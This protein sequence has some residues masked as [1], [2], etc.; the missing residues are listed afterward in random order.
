MIALAA[1]VFLGCGK[2]S[3]KPAA[4]SGPALT[5]C[6]R[7]AEHFVDL[8]LA[9]TPP[10][11]GEDLATARKKLAEGPLLL[12][13]SESVSDATTACMLAATTVAA[14]RVCITTPEVEVDAALPPPGN[15][16]TARAPV[17]LAPGGTLTCAQAV[18]HVLDLALSEATTPPEMKQQITNDRPGMMQ[19]AIAKCEADQL[20]QSELA[21]VIGIQQFRQLK[22]C[23]QRKRDPKLAPPSP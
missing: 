11:A 17:Q 14:Y 19:K 22:T 4:D 1:L 8:A 23:T 16:P 5:A 20:T 18:D 6:Q 10:P 21:C 15:D 7:A 12:C 9:E 2:K 13:R 3:P